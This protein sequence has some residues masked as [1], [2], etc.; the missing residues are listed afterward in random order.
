MWKFP[1]KIPYGHHIAYLSLLPLTPYH[2]VIN[3]GN[4]Q[5]IYTAILCRQFS[6][7]FTIFP[8]L[9]FFLY[10]RRFIERFIELSLCVIRVVRAFPI[11]TNYHETNI[12]S[13]KRWLNWYMLFIPHSIE[14]TITKHSDTP[15]ITNCA[16]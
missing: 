16:Q 2:V 6:Y 9:G 7:L 4:F 1:W 5:N 12:H 11:R 8:F 14:H 3:D 10:V 15:I 13:H